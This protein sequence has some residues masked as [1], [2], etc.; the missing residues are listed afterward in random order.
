MANSP[1]FLRISSQTFEH[2]SGIGYQ[3]EGS[4]PEQ[5][6]PLNALWCL[7][8]STDGPIRDDTGK[9]IGY[10]FRNS[11][12]ELFDVYPGKVYQINS[13]TTA[14]DDDGCPEDICI[15]YYVEI[16]PNPDYT[17]NA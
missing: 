11:D 16:V 15:E 17:E 12:K 9:I 5:F 10:R 2:Y 4:M 1:F 7:H 6:I 8:L 3:V 13:W 14:V